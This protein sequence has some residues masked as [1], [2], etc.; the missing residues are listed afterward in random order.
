MAGLVKKTTLSDKTDLREFV[1]IVGNK[2][3]RNYT[4]ADGT[5]YKD[6]LLAVPAQ[7]KVDPVQGPQHRPS[8]PR[9]RKARSS[10][11]GHSSSPR[12]YDQ[13]QADGC[14]EVLRRADGRE[15][16]VRN[17]I[18]GLRIKPTAQTG[19]KYKTRYPFTT[20]RV[21]EAIQWS[22]LHRVQVPESLEITADLSCRATRPI[23]GALD[24][25]VHRNAARRNHA[26]SG[27]GRK[28]HRRHQLLRHHDSNGRG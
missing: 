18:E 9:S 22:D 5:L 6:T 1:E 19:E 12:R 20:V 24:R 28:S 27:V 14:A 2:P 16:N 25:P 17:P 7:R 13:R 8:G 10:A 11:Q 26:T 15:K 21:A 23:L 3:I 4:A